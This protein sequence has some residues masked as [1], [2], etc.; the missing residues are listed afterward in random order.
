MKI[1][2]DHILADFNQIQGSKSSQDGCSFSEMLTQLVAE[3]I[4]QSE[5]AEPVIEIQSSTLEGDTGLSPVWFKLNGLLDS[6]EAYGQ[7]LGNPDKTLKDFE[8]L[9][10]SM[11]LQAEQ[12]EEN[13][14]EIKDPQLVQLGQETLTA[15]R[16]ES[17]KYWRGD[18]IS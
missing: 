4:P 3:K 7:A 10:R 12:L 15:V 11:E 9:L 1:T 16:V 6:L 17:L 13:L 18:Y 2:N 14:N 8:P 5:A